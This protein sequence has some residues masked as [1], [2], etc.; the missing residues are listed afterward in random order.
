M[1]ARASAAA[2]EAGAPTGEVETCAGSPGEARCNARSLSTLR[3]ME[4]TLHPCSQRCQAGIPD[5]LVNGIS[6]LTWVIFEGTGQLKTPQLGENT[7][8]DGQAE[9]GFST[10]S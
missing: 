10:G 8:G 5:E 7:G 9:G 1:P 4:D 6:D 3:Q 2:A